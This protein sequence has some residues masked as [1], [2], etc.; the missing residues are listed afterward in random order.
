MGKQVLLIM[1][2]QKYKVRFFV[3]IPIFQ[4][5]GGATR[6]RVVAAHPGDGKWVEE[7]DVSCILKEQNL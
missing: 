5:R 6:Q 4:V 2:K 3:Y 7:M 1:G